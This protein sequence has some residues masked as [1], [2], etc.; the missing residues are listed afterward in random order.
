MKYAA[1]SPISQHR[2]YQRM[3]KEPILKASML[4]FQSMKSI[5]YFLFT[6]R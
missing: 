3:A 2:A 5:F 4:G 6:C 1:R